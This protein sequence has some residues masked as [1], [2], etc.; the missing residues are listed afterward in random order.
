MKKLKVKFVV[1]FCMLFLAIG[2][3]AQASLEGVWNT[4]TENTKIE[5]AAVDGEY[6]GKTVSSDNAKAKIGKV[7][8]KDVKANGSEWEG[9]LF[10][11]KKGKWVDAVLKVVDNQ[12][13]VTVKRG[14]RSKTLEW[15][16]A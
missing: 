5:I 3:N 9:K 10:A 14:W 1:A 7:I 4:G 15:A 8:L 2:M 16:K 12:L 6:E 13:V 11:A